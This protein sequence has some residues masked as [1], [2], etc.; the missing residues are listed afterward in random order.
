MSQVRRNFEKFWKLIWN[1]VG[2]LRKK[3]HKDHK[4][5]PLFTNTHVYIKEN[6]QKETAKRREEKSPSTMFAKELYPL[7]KSLEA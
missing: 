2:K 7:C 5:A 6:S 4:L 3:L 1:L